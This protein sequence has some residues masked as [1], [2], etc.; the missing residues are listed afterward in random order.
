MEGLFESEVFSLLSRVQELLDAPAG[1][2]PDEVEATLTQLSQ[3]VRQLEAE[4]RTQADATSR[5]ALLGKVK[6]FKDDV[7]SLRA[8]AKIAREK[9]E[10]ESLMNRIGSEGTAEQ[11]D[12]L[13]NVNRRMEEG[14]SKL[15]QSRRA[16]MEI[17]E[18]AAGVSE[19]LSQNRATILGTKRKLDETNSLTGAATGLL[20]KLEQNERFKKLF[21]YGAMAIVALVLLIL[22]YHLVLG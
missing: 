4:A 20:R 7:K 21:S 14:T 8:K 10:R 11:E 1:S 22:A 17:E 13:M 19:Q 15:E 12:R 18:T 2:D 9:G 5:K 16:M 3:A 6:K